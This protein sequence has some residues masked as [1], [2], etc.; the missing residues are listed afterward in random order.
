M[1][2]L[3]L[4]RKVDEAFKIQYLLSDCIDMILNKNPAGIKQVFDSLGI[5][6]SFVR[7]PLVQVDAS[8]SKRIDQF[9]KD[10]AK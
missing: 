1:I 3:G 7:L 10:T 6:D 5:A 4:N 9:V 8:L 2:R